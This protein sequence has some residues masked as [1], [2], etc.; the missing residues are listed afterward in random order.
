MRL[1]PTRTETRV[2]TQ[3]PGCQSCLERFPRAGWA[4][5]KAQG[6]GRKRKQ[7]SDAAPPDEDVQP[8]EEEVAGAAKG[9]VAEAAEVDAAHAAA[10]D[11]ESPPETG[12]S[13]AASD[14]AEPE[15]AGEGQEGGGSGQP[16]PA[17]PRRFGVLSSRHLSTQLD[18][19]EDSMETLLSYLEVGASLGGERGGGP[20]W[21]HT[22]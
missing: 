1:A 5:V 3:A 18:M 19:R 13:A 16:A 11:G 6:K 17:P 2:V 15:A 20:P 12:C 10:E 21:T 8:S 14:A 7:P 4:Q 9:L 22:L